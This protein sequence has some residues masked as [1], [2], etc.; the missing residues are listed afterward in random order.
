[1][2]YQIRHDKMGARVHWELRRKYG[3]ECIDK[4]IPSSTSRSKDG[5]FEIFW[6]RKILVGKGIEFNKPD[7]IV[8]DKA[9]KKWTIVDFCVPWDG[10]IKV[11][12]DEKKEKYSILANEIRST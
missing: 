7:V 5:L 10:N 9:E 4:C 1:M 12:E 11:R 8:V 2:Q 3:I 6:N